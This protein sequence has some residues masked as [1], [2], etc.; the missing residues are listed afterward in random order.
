MS[1]APLTAAIYNAR[2]VY[3]DD[4]DVSAVRVVTR[5]NSK[6]TYKVAVVSA[7][8]R[9]EHIVWTSFYHSTAHRLA[10]SVSESYGVTLEDTRGKA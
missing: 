2:K 9:T 4:A 1:E 5:A 3:P 7:D 6:D 10:T 8:G